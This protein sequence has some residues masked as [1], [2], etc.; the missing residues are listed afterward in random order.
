MEPRSPIWVCAQWWGELGEHLY[1]GVK[2]RDVV[3]GSGAFGQTLGPSQSL[4]GLARPAVLRDKT[5]PP[6][7]PPW[8]PAQAWRECALLGV[9]RYAQVLWA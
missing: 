6:A 3:L 2:G 1:L 8:V 7:R 9:S 5:G 4:G